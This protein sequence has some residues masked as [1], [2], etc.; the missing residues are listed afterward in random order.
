[1]PPTR[2]EILKM[3]LTG[4]A[5][6]LAP[7]PVLAMPEIASARPNRKTLSIVQGATD[8]TKT[9]FSIVHADGVEIFPSVMAGANRIAP[10]EVK[11]L[12]H[13]GQGTV[14][15]QAFFSG[16]SPREDLRL[17][18]QSASQEILDERAFGTL[19]PDKPSLTFAI[20]SCMD[21]SKHE[22][23][24]WND[25]ASRSP[26]I[27]LFIGDATYADRGLNPDE[28][29]DPAILWRRFAE[30]REMLEI[31]HQPRLI[32][33]LAVWDDHDFGG[34]DTHSTNFAFVKESQE[35]FLSYFPQDPRY[36]RF[37]ERGPGIASRFAFRGQQLML[38]DGRSFR[39]PKESGERY[40]HW[41]Q[42]QE[43]WMVQR[44]AEGEGVT[45]LMNGT[46]IF[47]T[48]PMKES[49]AGDHPVQF[50]GALKALAATGRKV[51]FASGDVHYSEISKIEATQL[52][53]ETF[54]VTSSSIHSP[55]FPGFPNIVHNP[56]R[57]KS[58][59]KRNY[60][61]VSCEAK[62]S[63]YLVQARS[64]PAIVRYEATLIL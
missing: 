25:L 52:G 40:A 21:D 13:P 36:C 59:G 63:R 42:A 11:T 54:E 41:G 50:E 8:D 27:I 20:C 22:A 14:V 30:A 5:A 37:L 17:V 12:R 43:E 64:S 26:D 35:N 3:G 62:G 39:L 53:Y 18:V 57:I 1:M 55:V 2:R 33:I 29:V 38:L 32:P 47:P 19:D 16:L 4:A 46:Q 28:L 48:Y 6:M 9:Q 31:Y 44:V 23:T 45:W 7:F 49:V 60:N 34:N 58:T 51:V 15:T 24:I 56:R 10:D 61:L